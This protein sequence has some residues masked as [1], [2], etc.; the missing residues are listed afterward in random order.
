MAAIPLENHLG[1]YLLLKATVRDRSTGA[2]NVFYPAGS[3]SR[4]TRFADNPAHTYIP[5]LLSKSLNFGTSF[6]SGADPVKISNNA[7]SGV[8]DMLDLNRELEYLHDYSWDNAELELF[9]GEFD[10][11]Y[12]AWTS[13]AKMTASDLIGSLEKKR[14]RLRDA[15]W[16]LQCPVHNKYYAGT[17][18]IEGGANLTGQ[19]KPYLLGYGNNLPAVQIDTAN[20]SFNSRGRH[21]P[22]VQ[23]A[24]EVYL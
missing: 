14:I 20:S 9:R 8:L 1:K 7:G 13:V 11:L 6:F 2:T 22:L 16:R 18:G 3:F 19:W 5:G 15:A 17:G 24:T 12:S 4:S 21:V 23:F 10:A